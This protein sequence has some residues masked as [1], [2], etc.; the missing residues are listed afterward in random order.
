MAVFKPSSLFS[1]YHTFIPPKPASRGIQW[2]LDARRAIIFFRRVQAQDPNLEAGID[3]KIFG[4]FSPD[5]SDHQLITPAHAQ[6]ESQK[7]ALRYGE[8]ADNSLQ[9][10]SLSINKGSAIDNYVALIDIDA[11]GPDQG[12]E[13][14]KLPFIPK[15]LNYN[16]ESSFVAIKPIGANNPRYQFTGAEDKLEFEIDWHSFDNDRRDVITN[17]RKIESL[18]KADAYTGNPHRVIL[19]WGEEDILFAAHEF[20]VTAAPYKMTQFSNGHHTPD[21]ELHFTGMLPVQAYQKITLSRITSANLSKVQIEFVQ[22]TLA[23]R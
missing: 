22:E 18:S 3:T 21:G 20:I 10:T 23:T 2:G 6:L 14:I 16:S 13:V 12:H 8:G 9:H 15:E 7:D 5:T 1:K 19:K 4:S 17:C 11:G